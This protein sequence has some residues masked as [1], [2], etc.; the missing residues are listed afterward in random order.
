MKTQNDRRE[1]YSSNVNDGNIMYDSDNSKNG[2]DGGMKQGKR[3]LSPQAKL[4]TWAI[5]GSE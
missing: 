4:V 5:I 3:D 1:R 2:T